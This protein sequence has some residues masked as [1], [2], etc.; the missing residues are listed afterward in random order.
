[1]VIISFRF[2]VSKKIKYTIKTQLENDTTG[3][4]YIFMIKR[5]HKFRNLKR[6]QNSLRGYLISQKKLVIMTYFI[7]LY[8]S[9]V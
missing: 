6:C 7:L 2:L 8:H 9:D 4:W 3:T 5:Q 1:M